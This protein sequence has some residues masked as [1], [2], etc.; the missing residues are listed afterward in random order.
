MSQLGTFS[1]REVRKKIRSYPPIESR[2]IGTIEL[3]IPNK[4][5]IIHLIILFGS[6]VVNNKPKQLIENDKVAIAI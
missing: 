1:T 5:M 2:Y 3:F 4:T 6:R